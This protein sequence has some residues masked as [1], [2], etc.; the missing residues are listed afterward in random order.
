MEKEEFTYEEPK[1]RGIFPIPEILV[2]EGYDTIGDTFSILNDP[3]GS[4]ELK[5]C[6]IGHA[7]QEAEIKPMIYKN[8][9]EIEQLHRAIYKGFE[10]MVMSYGYHPC[11]Y[12]KIPVGHQLYGKD[13]NDIDIDCHGG[14]TFASSL[15]PDMDSDKSN[16]WIGWDYAHCYDYAGCMET[17]GETPNVKRWTTE[18]I[19][20]ECESVINQITSKYK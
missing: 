17:M 10:F 3:N 9:H 6:F 11:A 18:E 2:K 7:A 4:N 13:Y 19:I 20:E 5:L 12:V 15:L 1:L 8:E 16:Y 14:L